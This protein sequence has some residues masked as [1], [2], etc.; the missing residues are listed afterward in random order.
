AVAGDK[1]RVAIPLPASVKVEKPYLFAEADGIID[2]DAKQEF[3]RSGDVLIAELARKDVSPK[4]FAA[5]VAIGDGQGLEFRAVPGAVPE[6]GAP[7]GQLGLGAMWWALLGAIA[8]GVLL[9]LMPC[10][11]PILALKALHV[12]RAGG[13]AREARF[14]ALAYAAGAIVGTGALGVVL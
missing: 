4:A 12:S 3:S 9:N 14:D 5:V 11:F 1:L 13:D 8:G 2:Y 10:V 7:L 6:D